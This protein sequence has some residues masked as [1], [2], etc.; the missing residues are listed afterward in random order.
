VSEG[1]IDDLDGDRIP[2][3]LAVPTRNPAA[4]LE[5]EGRSGSDLLVPGLIGVAAIGLLYFAYTK[6]KKKTAPKQDEKPSA[7]VDAISF[8]KQYVTYTYDPGWLSNVFEPYLLYQYEEGV[9]FT[10]SKATGSDFYDAVWT[11][12]LDETRKK[13]LN[14]FRDTHTAITHDGVK[15]FATIVAAN[16]KA[17]A[18]VKFNKWIDD[19]AKQFQEEY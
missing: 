8:S 13:V 19:L 1:E 10:R 5:P 14:A 9:L 18:V 11:V 6:N 16:P 17:P 12:K 4:L 3:P 2:N 15:S 7:P